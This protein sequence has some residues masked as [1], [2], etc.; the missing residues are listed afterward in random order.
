MKKDLGKFC[1]RIIKGIIRLCYP[2]IEVY[3]TEHLSGEPMIFVGNHCKMNGPISCELYFP[4]KRYTWCAGEMMHLKEVPDYAYQDFWAEKPVGIRWFYRLLSYVIAP[5]S[6]CVFN[7]A[8]TIGV[9]HDTRIIGTFK[10]TV[11]RLTEGAGIVIFP[12]HNVPYN[13]IL[14]EF[15]NRFVDVAKLYYKKTGKEIAFVP[16]Y[17][18]PSLH[19]M[20][21]GK[22][23]R[24][25]AANPIEEERKRICSYLM[26]EITQIAC[27][28][29]L[30]TVIPYPNIPR[31]A[32][33]VNRLQE[34]EGEGAK[35]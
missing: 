31:K 27:K 30:H 33:P 9:Y 28:L 17:I 23:I 13:H 29:P 25:C 34:I 14:W 12:E 24:F 18:A 10:N 19:R 7:H 16:L 6:V 1:Y 5:L 22:P 21:L 2:K 26:E 3:G 15:Q 11:Q 32:Y 8:D 4:M 20:V 35:G